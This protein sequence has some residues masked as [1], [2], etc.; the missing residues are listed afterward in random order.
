MHRRGEGSDGG[1]KADN[2]RVR[3]SPYIR[4]KCVPVE[5]SNDR[6]GSEPKNHIIQVSESIY[7]RWK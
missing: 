4:S 2:E 5:R 1:Y 7:T 6:L 3:T